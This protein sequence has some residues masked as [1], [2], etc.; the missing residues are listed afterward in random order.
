MRVFCCSALCS[1]AHKIINHRQ[2]E[3]EPSRFGRRTIEL[4]HEGRERVSTPHLRPSFLHEK[5]KATEA[6]KAPLPSSAAQDMTG[7]AVSPHEKTRGHS[8]SV[9]SG[10]QELPSQSHVSRALA[11]H[12]LSNRKTA[13]VLCY[14]TLLRLQ[15]PQHLRP[16]L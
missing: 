7:R 12:S 5:V 1:V 6:L 10:V 9:M 16:A 3:L 13:S 8:P 2:E 11:W 4:G 15:V 14:R